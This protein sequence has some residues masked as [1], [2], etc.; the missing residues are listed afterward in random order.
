MSGLEIVGVVLGA[1]PLILE[2]AKGLRSH[3]EMSKSWWNFR[4]E[5]STFVSIIEGEAIAY[6]QNLEFLLSPLDL[7]Q[8]QLRGLQEDPKSPQWHDSGVQKKLRD[9]IKNQYF[10]WFM[11]QL[12]DMNESL[13]ELYGL[14]PIIDGKV[15]S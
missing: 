5:Y 1:F 7:D 15:G 8:D 2:G 9:R 10:N 13:D 3:L 12:F 4:T 6:S 11:R 14:L